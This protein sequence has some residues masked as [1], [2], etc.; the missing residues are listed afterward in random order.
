MVKGGGG[1]VN[2]Y[3]IVSEM[4]SQGHRV[5]ILA[6]GGEREHKTSENV[7]GTPVLRIPKPELPDKFWPLWPILEPFYLRRPLAALCGGFDSFVAIDPTYGLTFKRLYPDRPLIYRLEAT[8]R[9]HAA[10]VRSKVE[11]SFSLKSG[12]LQ[13]VRRLMRFENEAIEQF[14][15]KK[16]D[17]LVV[18]SE[19]MK[20]ELA[21]LYKFNTDKVRVIPNGV[22][23][24]RYSEAK[25]R[26][27]TLEQLGKDLAART[28][29]VYCGRLVRMK[30]VEFLLRS[31][32]AMKMKD[33][34][35]L[36]IL[37]DGEERKHLE[38]RARG[39]G[40]SSNVR[41]IGK[42]D[43]VEEFLAAADI[44]VLPSTYEPFGN[45]LIEAMAAGRPC[46]ALKPDG[47]RIRTA[48]AEIIQDGETGYLVP[49]EV[50]RLA[51]R[52]DDLVLNRDLR[53]RIGKRA[54]IVCKERYDWSKCAR[55]YVRLMEL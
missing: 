25:P 47:I 53:I 46:V 24:C 20:R 31:V 26:T 29:I 44:F 28:V 39:L 18:K 16:C 4:L 5:L 34:C 23:F 43:H 6:Q 9:S 49:A 30:N 38:A 17:A 50:F 55:E 48:S 36:A 40:I 22:D 54:Q 15:W 13:A 2:T 35:I 3:Y 21:T 41:F 42:T 52:L 33:D 8:V 14:V 11:E 37:G 19:F 51:G 7:N 32:A 1:A 10:A 27:A 12:K 45:A